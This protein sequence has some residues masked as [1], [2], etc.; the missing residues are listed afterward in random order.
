LGA[1]HRP[2]PRLSPAAGCGLSLALAL[3]LACLFSGAL[4]L[5]LRGEIV[6]RHG[7]AGESR[8]WLIRGDTEEGLGLSWVRDVDSAR[9]GVRCESSG[10]VFLLWK[11]QTAFPPVEVCEC[12]RLAPEGATDEGACPP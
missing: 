4:T 6:L 9:E 3:A 11:S 5:A 2:A 8:I 12:Y 1:A 10:V 7:V